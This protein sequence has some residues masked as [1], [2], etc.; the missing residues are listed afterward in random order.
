MELKKHIVLVTSY[1][2]GNDSIKKE[3]M[4]KTICKN[5]KS[6]GLD[7]CLATHS[8]IDIETQ[9]YCDIVV[10]D[11]DNSFDY[12][13]KPGTGVETNHGVAEIKSI[14]NALTIIQMRGYTHILKTSYDNTP[15]VNFKDLIEKCESTGKQLITAKWFGNDL[16]L[17]S[18]LFYCNIDL[19]WKTCGP[20]MIFDYKPIGSWAFENSWFAS[21]V[22][23][24]YL[25]ILMRFE[26]YSDFFGYNMV[27]YSHNGGAVV[28]DY[29]YE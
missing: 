11:A 27:Q 26:S 6:Q 21:V 8:P 23:L 3:L 20:D 28:Y 15:A 5:I 1:C 18:H 24:G 10:Y 2:G 22:D 25:D 12:F 19:F 7:V 16:T 29:P 13:G 9:K 14:W 17:G 4:T